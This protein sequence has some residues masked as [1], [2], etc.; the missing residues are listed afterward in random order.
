[1]RYTALLGVMCGLVL[2]ACGPSVEIGADT[3]GLDIPATIP[4][5][6]VVLNALSTGISQLGGVS[7]DSVVGARQVIHVHTQDC[8]AGVGGDIDWTAPD[9]VRLCPSAFADPDTLLWVIKHELGHVLG[10]RYHLDCATHAVLVPRESCYV[11]LSQA[12][13]QYHPEDVEAICEAGRCDL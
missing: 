1:M 7:R 2:S 10:V 6:S 4:K 11:R 3:I 8:A 13:H 9:T 12:G 5:R